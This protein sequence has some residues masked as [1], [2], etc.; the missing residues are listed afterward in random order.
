MRAA[1]LVKFGREPGPCDPIFFDPDAKTP[2][3]FPPQRY[4]DEV[5][6]AMKAAGT[7]PQFIYAFEKT[8]L[9]LTRQGANN[10]D[11]S[12]LAE[13]RAAIAEYSALEDAQAKKAR[14]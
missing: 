7:P 4:R 1:F 11:R 12:D 3:P 6:R 13:Y 2:Q 5:L 8:G 9:V 14:D 10:A